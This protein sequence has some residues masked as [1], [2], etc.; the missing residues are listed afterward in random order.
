MQ[1]RRNEAPRTYHTPSTFLLGT[2]CGH[3]TK[4]CVHSDGKG[5]GGDLFDQH[6]PTCN[7]AQYSG[8]LSCCHH[9]RIMLDADQIDKYSTSRAKLRYHMKVK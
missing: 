7:S 4:N 5:M 8:G 3:F 1:P 2:S 6:N 9:E